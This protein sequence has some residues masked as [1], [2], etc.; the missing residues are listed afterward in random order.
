M[1]GNTD[2]RRNRPAD[3]G[4]DNDP[5]IRDESALQPGVNTISS[6]ENDDVNQHLTRTA[7][8]DFR[9]DSEGDEK[10]D[11]RFDE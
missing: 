7:S 2:P 9:E 5:N 1:T 8:D 3:E 11:K 4:K 6:S 10:A